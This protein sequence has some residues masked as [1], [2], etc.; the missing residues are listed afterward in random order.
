M[1]IPY[2]QLDRINP[3]QLSDDEDLK[4]SIGVPKLN[5][6]SINSQHKNIPFKALTLKSAETQ[7]NDFT[8]IHS[9]FSEPKIYEIPVEM[10][11]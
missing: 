10:E 7:T 1:P 9:L 5:N 3:S 2:F 6:F 8:F 11:V 4:T